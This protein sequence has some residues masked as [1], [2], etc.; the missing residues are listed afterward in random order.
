MVFGGGVNKTKQTMNLLNVDT[1]H[2]NKP[3]RLSRSE[4]FMIFSF[5]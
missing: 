2:K 1:I 4:R 3:L 5:A